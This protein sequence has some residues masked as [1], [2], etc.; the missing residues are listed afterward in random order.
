MKKELL[1]RLK[2]YALSAG[3]LS[4]S[5]TAADAQI[6]YTDVNPDSTVT[7][8]GNNY[9]LDLNNDNTADFDISIQSTQSLRPKQTLQN[10]FR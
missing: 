5:A 1:D 8:A 2:K 3:A 7:G 9:M 4:V 6:N 10:I